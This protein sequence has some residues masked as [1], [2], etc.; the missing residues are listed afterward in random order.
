MAGGRNS[1][2]AGNLGG[3]GFDNAPRNNRI[4]LFIMIAC[5]LVLV[6]I[7]YSIS[8]DKR[9]AERSN[10]EV[11]PDLSPASSRNN[12]YYNALYETLSEDIDERRYQLRTPLAGSVGSVSG[13]AAA[14]Q[15]SENSELKNV[16]VVRKPPSDEYTDARS[17]ILDALKATPEI[18]FAEAP[19][20]AV[21]YEA[22]ELPDAALDETANPALI[23]TYPAVAYAGDMDNRSP[24]EIASD[25]DRAV[26]NGGV[27]GSL[28]SQN[29]EDTNAAAM[30]HQDR[31]NSF[32]NSQSV[33]KDI[34]SEY[35]SS[36]RRAPR[37]RYELKAGSIISGV[38]VGGIN[39]DTPGS[40]L[41]QIT[42]N[43]YDTASGAYILIPQGARM[44][45]TYDSHVVYGQHRI[46]VVW[47][48][49]VFP[50]GTSLNLEGM[51]GGDQSG[52]A[53][54][55]QKIDNHYSR[56]IG[57]AL[58]ASVFT[59]A[60]KVATNNDKDSENNE[61]KVAEAVME[62]VTGVGAKLA[63]KNINVSPTLRILPG[64]R[65]SIITT[66]DVAFAEPYITP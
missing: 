23:S 62:S 44:V 22:E 30:A 15:G 53:G 66:K 32:I 34:D 19:G 36:A 50:D 57:A 46:V 47:N 48:R 1:P 61:N 28:F 8:S 33:A 6:F 58:L 18:K 14:G 31:N 35:L 42:E 59:A 41:G 3:S 56:V 65:F 49:I 26:M 51:I 5:F 63:E 43:V 10:D 20:S 27:G 45:G 4:V 39:S 52:N 21:Q 60:G 29:T 24:E 7:L 25:L 13:A 11:F 64:Y 2:D 55:K 9:T 38:M 54:F 12:G 37:S 40:V 16:R 17:L